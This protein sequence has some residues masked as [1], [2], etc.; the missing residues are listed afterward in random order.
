MSQNSWEIC[1]IP[2][3]LGDIPLTLGDRVGTMQRI[4]YK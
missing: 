2:L 3:T 1:N 4:Q